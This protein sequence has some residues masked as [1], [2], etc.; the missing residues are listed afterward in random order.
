MKDCFFRELKDE[1]RKSSEERQNSSLNDTLTSQ[2]IENLHNMIKNLFEYYVT[3]SNKFEG[4]KN[5]LNFHSDQI[6]SLGLVVYKD[7]RDEEEDEED[8]SELQDSLKYI[9]KLI[10]IHGLEGRIKAVLNDE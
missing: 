2:K 6:E 10:E 4:M 1:M 3:L 5:T 9:Q 7:E 8:E